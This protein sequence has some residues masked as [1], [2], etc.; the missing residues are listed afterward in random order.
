VFFEF[1]FSTLPLPIVFFDDAV[2]RVCGGE[3]AKGFE[4]FCVL[5]EFSCGYLFKN[6]SV[7]RNGD[8]VAW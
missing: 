2:P 7:S 8:S 4:S 5:V 1:A 6:E 3:F